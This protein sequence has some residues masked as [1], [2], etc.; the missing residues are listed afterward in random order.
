M[1]HHLGAILSVTTGIFVAR[2]FGEIHALL[3]H[4]TGDQLWSHQIVRAGEE[5]EEHLRAQFPQLDGLEIPRL[6]SPQD[7]MDWL[8][9]QCVRFGAEH[10]VQ[11]LRAGDHTVID[12]VTELAMNYPNAK[13]V[14]IVL[15]E[16]P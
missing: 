5:C 14:P 11:P 9:V 15:E 7:Y 1:K 4:M 16:Q 12:P 2:E 8:D 13:V 6:A 3:D 10:E